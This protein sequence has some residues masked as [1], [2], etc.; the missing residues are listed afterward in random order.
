MTRDP[1]FLVTVD[2]RGVFGPQH[3]AGLRL[4]TV[5]EVPTPW[6]CL[7]HD[8]RLAGVDPATVVRTAGRTMAENAA[9]LQRYELDVAQLSQPDVEDLVEAG[10]RVWYAQA[11]RGPCS[12][13]S[14]Y[15]RR[16]VLAAKREE[17]ASM[18][19][20]M[21]ATLTWL[22]GAQPAE[23]AG[24]VAAYFPGIAPKRLAAALAR[25]KRLGIWGRDLMLPRTGYER[26]RDSLVSGGLVKQGVPY[27]D[28]VDNRLAEK[29]RNA[30]G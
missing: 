2:D 12:Y 18:L 30:Q 22:H 28:A 15:A 17:L 20:A 5:S 19:R 21:Q 11:D 25:Y 1:F 7:Q 26:L 13:T 27:E 10:C 6:L 24:T 9:A 14:L 29:A 16:S 23:L 4:G 3:L 8:M